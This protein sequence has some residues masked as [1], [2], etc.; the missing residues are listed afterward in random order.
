MCVLYLMRC[1]TDSTQY[2]HLILQLHYLNAPGYFNYIVQLTLHPFIVHGVYAKGLVQ[3][4][5]FRRPSSY[6]SRNDRYPSLFYV[7]LLYCIIVIVIF[8]KHINISMNENPQLLYF[9][10]SFH[11]NSEILFRLH[12]EFFCDNQAKCSR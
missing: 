6:T 5:F 10:S 8:N 9:N 12:F 3:N 2:S 4:F 7:I 1:R 11:E